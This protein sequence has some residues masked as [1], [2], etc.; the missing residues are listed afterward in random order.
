MQALRLQLAGATH[1]VLPE[2]VATVDDRVAV[3]SNRESS[4]MADSV[5][6]ALRQHD[7][8]TRG[9]PSVFT[10]SPT[11][12]AVAEPLDRQR[13]PGSGSRS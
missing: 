9:A 1:V 3:S 4:A 5:R 13:P 8:T 12:A 6:R 11:P 10:S 7:H 2:G